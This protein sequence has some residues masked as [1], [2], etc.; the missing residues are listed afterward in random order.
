[1]GVQQLCCWSELVR[2]HECASALPSNVCNHDLL[3]L[4]FVIRK[5]NLS[6]S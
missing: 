4:S 1:M 6:W 5:D 2:V 3:V